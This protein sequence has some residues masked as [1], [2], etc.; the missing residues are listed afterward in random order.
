MDLLTRQAASRE[1]LPQ[2]RY[3]VGARLHEDLRLLGCGPSSRIL[4]AGKTRKQKRS[5]HNE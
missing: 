3:Q 1:A 5:G 4:G 2:L